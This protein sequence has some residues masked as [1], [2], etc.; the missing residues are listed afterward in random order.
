MCE[1]MMNCIQGL[2]DKSLREEVIDGIS[3]DDVLDFV[4]LDV[5]FS[6]VIETQLVN[7]WGPMNEVEV[8][9]WDD[10]RYAIWY[11]DPP[12]FRVISIERLKIMRARYLLHSKA[13]QRR[14]LSNVLQ[15][16]DNDEA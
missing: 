12:D 16:N 1:K 2:I 3:I 8:Q 13:R 11:H 9:K 4:D 6:P 7:T 14:I 5:A 10:G 15:E